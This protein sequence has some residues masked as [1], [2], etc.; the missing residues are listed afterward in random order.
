M[1]V[2]DMTSSY[3]GFRDK[4][5]ENCTSI[6]NFGLIRPPAEILI[7]LNLSI[8]SVYSFQPGGDVIGTRNALRV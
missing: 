2:E 6:Q 3:S 4:T 7:A 1:P 8:Y 5:L